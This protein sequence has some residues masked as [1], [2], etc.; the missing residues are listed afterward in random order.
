MILYKK[1]KTIYRI[2]DKMITVSKGLIP[3]VLAQGWEN[4]LG[5]QEKTARSSNGCAVRFSIIIIFVML[6]LIAAQYHLIQLHLPVYRHLQ[7]H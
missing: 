5:T 7:P 6:C 2:I 1:Y 4:D 3:P